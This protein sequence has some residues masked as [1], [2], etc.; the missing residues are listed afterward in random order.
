MYIGKL[1]YHFDIDTGI[2]TATAGRAVSS[3]NAIYS[4]EG[5]RLSEAPQ[6][7]LYIQ[8]GKLRMK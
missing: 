1:C 3:D 5:A 2:S 6:K 4:V 7:G 8:G